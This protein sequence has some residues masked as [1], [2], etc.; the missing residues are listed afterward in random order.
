MKDRIELTILRTFI[1]DEE[2]LR[3]VLPFIDRE[4]FEER[5]EKIIFEEISDFAQQYDKCLTTEILSIEIQ[6]RDDISEEEYK[7]VSQLLETLS[8]PSSHDQWLLDT[9]EIWC[10]D[11]AIYLALME[12]I[13]IADGKDDKK[14]RDAI[15]SILSDALA[16]SFDNHIGH[17]YLED[18]EA[19]YESYHKKDEKIPF[20]LEFFNRITKGG[21][22]NKTLNV[23]LAGTGVGKSLFMCH[24]ASSCLLQ[25]KNVLYITL[26]MAEEK[27]AERI[28]ANLLDVNIKDITDLPRVLFE[29]KVTNLAE[30]TQGQLIIK[31]YP[32]AS[33]HS[34]H[35]KALLNEL[36][37]KKSFRP[38]IIFIDYLNI[39]ASSRYRGAIG[40]NSYSY[41]KA[42]AEEL[43][44][45]AVE[46]NVPIVSATQTTRAGFGS[47]DVD[48][49]DTSESFGL[50]ATADLMF[51]LISTEEL[52]LVNQIMV[53]QL[54]NRYNDPTLNKR[55]LVGIDRAKMRLFDCE[56]DN[57]GELVDANQEVMEKLQGDSTSD[58]F[59][60]LNF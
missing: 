43:R 32:T 10:R 18:Y 38:D 39:C 3:K 30:R 48:I 56:Q 24:F 7:N 49:T 54:K 35:F 40:V 29:N 45:L 46:S 26:E 8:E 55:F 34:G 44:G 50:P 47:S 11:R 1:H 19:R 17:D 6:K 2:Y 52:E 58:K 51:A 15:P 22:P 25:G 33:A 37:L 4:Y 28:D 36:A 21:L 13:S 20:D 9:T 60:K 14:G 31:E 5:I 53:K 27:I 12:S 42:I 16:V 41:I 59:A 23:A 57:N